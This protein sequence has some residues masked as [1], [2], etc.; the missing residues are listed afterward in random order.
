MFPL[1]AVIFGFE[2]EGEDIASPYEAE[3]A[4]SRARPHA[5][6]RLVRPVGELLLGD[7]HLAPLGALGWPH[8]AALLE[9]V[10]EPRRAR[11]A[12]LE[13]ALEHRRR[14]LLV[15]HDEAHRLL[16]EL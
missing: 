13:P 9:K 4:R 12:D 10:E 5:G 2:P 3:R 1:R 8:D 7:E 11:I 15:E 6:R 14:C 16:V